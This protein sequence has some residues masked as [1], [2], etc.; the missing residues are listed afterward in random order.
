MNNG[1]N[2]EAKDIITTDTTANMTESATIATSYLPTKENEC[3][4]TSAKRSLSFDLQSEIEDIKELK[5]H[6]RKNST[7]S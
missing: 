6:C 5:K 4:M 1:I 7:S 3:K 2:E